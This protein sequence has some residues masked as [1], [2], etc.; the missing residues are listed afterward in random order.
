[1][2]NRKIHKREMKRNTLI[3][4]A[5]HIHTG[6]SND[7]ALPTTTPAFWVHGDGFTQQHRTA[8][9]HGGRDTAQTHQAQ[10]LWVFFLFAF[11]YFFGGGALVKTKLTNGRLSPTIITSQH[12]ITTFLRLHFQEGIKGGWGGKKGGGTSLLWNMVTTWETAPHIAQSVWW[13][14]TLTGRESKVARTSI[15]TA[16]YHYNQY[17]QYKIYMSFMCQH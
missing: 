5:K 13:D 4:R 2:K 9:A 8:E 10:V 17:Y 7:G 12:N 3:E 11:V 6:W 16:W 15:S 14:N 1:M